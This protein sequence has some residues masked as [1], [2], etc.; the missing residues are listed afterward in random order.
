[1][2]NNYQIR[3]RIYRRGG[4]TMV[5]LMVSLMILSIVSTAA[6]YLMTGS[7]NAYRYVRTSANTTSAVE[8]A[9]RRIIH[10][11]RT[12]SALTTPTTG[13]ATSTLT[14]VTQP[15]T[16]NGNATY[17]VTYTLTGGNLTEND[18][19]YGT[20]TLVS[21]VTAFTVTLVNTTTPKMVQISITATVI[22][23]TL[24]R[25]QAAPV[26]RTFNV[27]FRNL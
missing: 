7:M 6:V 12:A 25:A 26:T 18:T 27:T 8:L 17:T 13:T 3:R 2:K 10:N 20:N 22:D 4:M 19:R 23:S 21:N 16:S 14:T 24:Q 11:V 15:D 5:E 9:I 1:M